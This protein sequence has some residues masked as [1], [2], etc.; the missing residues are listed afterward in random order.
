[1]GI[2]IHYHGRLDDRRVLPKILADARH[3]CFKRKLNYRDV[4]D[5]I[6]GRVERGQPPN[7]ES[8]PVDDTLRGILI[9]PHKN[10]EPM[11]LTFNRAG[12][13]CTYLAQPRTGCYWEN[14]DLSVETQ[15]APVDVHI[16]ICELLHLIRDH[17]AHGLQVKDEG[18]YFESGDPARLAQNVEQQRNATDQPTGAPDD[19]EDSDDIGEMLRDALV[20]SGKER[21]AA[22]QD[23]PRRR[24]WSISVQ[25]PAWKYGHG[26][27]ANRN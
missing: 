26:I 20:D 12:E 13:L 19:E 25:E 22:D 8:L 27:S 11:W 2:T 4:D 18:E 24:R 23:R 14:K 6:I 1:M 17:Y 5:R 15:L 7:V 3:F 21:N 9:Y 10:C 16:S